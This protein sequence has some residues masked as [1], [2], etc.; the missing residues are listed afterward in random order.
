MRLSP[1]SLGFARGD[2]RGDAMR[3]RLRTWQQNIKQ[4]PV[5]STIIVGAGLL[6]IAVL[7]ALIGGYFFHWNWTGYPNKTLW[8]W[9]QLL[10]I[11][12]VLAVGGYLFTYMTSKNEQKTTQ[13]RDQTERD[14][15]LDNQREVA[16]KEYID[17][18]SELLLEK[19]LRKS[20]EDDEVRKIARIRTLTVVSHLDKERKRRA[21]Q[22]LYESGLI[23]KDKRIIDLRRANLNEA[24]LVRA[25]LSGAD[26]S[27]ASLA[28]AV[29]MKANLNGANLCKTDLRY[30]FLV[31]ANLREANLCEAA[32]SEVELSAADLR[33]ASLKGARLSRANL[34][35]TTRRENVSKA[36]VT[37]ILFAGGAFVYETLTEYGLVTVSAHSKSFGGN[38]VMTFR[39]GANLSGADLSGAELD[40]AD[41]SGADLSGANLSEADL[42]GATITQPQL[43]QAKSLKGTIMPDGSIHP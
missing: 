31:Q 10:I 14:I 34:S 29:L 25:D 12:M 37:S 41:L 28:G 7:V 40:R 27:G 2:S 5:K 13:S 4:H 6:G 17:K 16:L 23:D 43:D 42:S 9:L 1:Q 15:A 30:A 38:L 3:A 32:L 18:I 19:K 36:L 39:N 20:E 26:L 21:I 8:D 35:N 33:E 11:P 24:N 22:F